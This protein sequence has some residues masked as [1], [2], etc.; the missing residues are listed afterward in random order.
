[1]E[2]VFKSFL[3]GE[4][5]SICYWFAHCGFLLEMAGS[6]SIAIYNGGWEDEGHSWNMVGGY[7]SFACRLLTF[8]VLGINAIMHLFQ[9]RVG[10]IILRIMRMEEDVYN[11]NSKG[12]N[13]REWL[14]QN[15]DIYEFVTTLHVYC[16]QWLT[17]TWMS[18]NVI[19]GWKIG[20]KCMQATDNTLYP[21][22]RYRFFAQLYYF[23]Y[24]WPMS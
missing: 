5:N 12:S 19:E 21:F 11:K 24:L 10:I 1:M 7:I 3:K 4:I 15:L 14:N 9:T 20:T 23:I 6:E 17:R 13:R 18:Q 22:N 2:G 16:L 8:V